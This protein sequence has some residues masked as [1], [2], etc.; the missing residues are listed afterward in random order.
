[1]RNVLS[2]KDHIDQVAKKISK[3]TGIMARARHHL[4]IQSLN[5][6]ILKVSLHYMDKHVSNKAKIDI[7]M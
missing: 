6:S 7:T 3:M 4:S 5:V 1:M 2:R